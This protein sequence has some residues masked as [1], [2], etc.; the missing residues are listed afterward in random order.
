MY[1]NDG[2]KIEVRL[3]KTGRVIYNNLIPMLAAGQDATNMFTLPEYILVGPAETIQLNV[4][5]PSSANN[6]V[7][8]AALYG[9]EYGL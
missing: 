1:L 8:L 9:I 3:L 2:A 6:F 4:E 5:V 7:Y